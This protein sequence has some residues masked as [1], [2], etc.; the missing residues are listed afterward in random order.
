MK[1][2][3]PEV[4]TIGA[5]LAAAITFGLLVLPRGN[6]TGR[7]RSGGQPFAALHAAA[8]RY[9]DR[10]GSRLGTVPVTGREPAS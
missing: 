8:C 7:L 9:L 4:I 1:R 6:R 10:A 3:H 5:F 2:V